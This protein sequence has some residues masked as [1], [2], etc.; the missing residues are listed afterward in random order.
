MLSSD[1]VDGEGA[2]DALLEWLVLGANLSAVEGPLGVHGLV[3]GDDWQL[4]LVA[5][6]SGDSVGKFLI[7]RWRLLVVLLGSGKL[8]DHATDVRDAPFE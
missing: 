7:E 5:G 2:V 1:G 6:F 4:D 3:G 8:L